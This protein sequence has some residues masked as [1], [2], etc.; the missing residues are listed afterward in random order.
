MDLLVRGQFLC[1]YENIRHYPFGQDF[2]S[3]GFFISGLENTLTELIPTN[4]TYTGIRTV[5]RYIIEDVQISSG[6]VSGDNIKGAFVT[7]K[8]SIDKLR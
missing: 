2:C 4:I 6:T 8:L 1:V 7:L 5:G 3:F